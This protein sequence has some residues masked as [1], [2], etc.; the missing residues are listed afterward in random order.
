[1][2]TFMKGT[3]WTIRPMAKELTFMQME[4]AMSAP[5]K[6]INRMDSVR[7]RG[8]TVHSIKATTSK[9][10]SMDKVSSLSLIRRCTKVNFV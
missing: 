2:A 6:M 3:G 5:G 8:L 7:R 4:L 1:M 9:V 10:R